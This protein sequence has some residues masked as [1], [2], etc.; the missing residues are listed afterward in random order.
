MHE[1]AAVDRVLEIGGYAA[2]YC[3]RLFVD[4]GA[5]VLRVECAALD[6][7]PPAWASDRAMDV[8]LHAGKR[9][10]QLRD[11][12]LLAELAGAA[13]V[14]ICE[15]ATAASL[16][17]LG[18]DDWQAPVQVALTP[19][20]RTGPRR[21]APATPS[22]ILAL[23]GY[24]YLMGD[25]GRAPLNLP[26]HYLEFQTGSL[27]YTAANACR[28]A[29]QTNRVDL[30]LF[31]TTM[32][33]SQ[34][35]TVRWHCAQEIRTRHGSDFYFV[36]PSELYACKDGWVYVNI[37][38]AFWDSFTLFIEQP[39]LALD[40]RFSDNDKRIANREELHRI[41]RRALADV[42]RAEVAERAEACRIPAGVVQTF[43]EVLNDPHLAARSFWQTVEMS[44][45]EVLRVPAVSYRLNNRAPT[46]LTLT[47]PTETLEPHHG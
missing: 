44:N 43:A 11:A 7:A 22:T 15:A 28:I 46:P 4:A 30:S 38:P 36:S 23:G 32:A 3:G 47:A 42:P 29:G 39:E 16:E 45:G 1:S 33:C 27:A 9:R 12:S 10:L 26:G 40:E 13:D 8:F 2:G 6:G 20:G 35:T 5:E 41:V 25:E 14:V 21:N 18:F 34:F 37:V 17:A 24:T 31:E 19:F